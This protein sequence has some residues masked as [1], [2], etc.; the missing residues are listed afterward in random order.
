MRFLTIKK[1]FY[2]L[3]KAWV[4][5]LKA[6][7]MANVENFFPL[8]EGSLSGVVFSLFVRQKPVFPKFTSDGLL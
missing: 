7:N 6:K 5:A 2:W 3:E 4:L 1:D 8:D